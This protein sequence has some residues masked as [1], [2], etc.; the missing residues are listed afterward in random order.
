MH[1]KTNEK[2]LIAALVKESWFQL[3]LDLKVSFLSADLDN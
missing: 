3:F 2:Q 1:K